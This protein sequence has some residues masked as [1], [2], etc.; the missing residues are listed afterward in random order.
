MKNALKLARRLIL[1]LLCVFA[2]LPILN[3]VVL[4]SVTYGFQSNGRPYSTAE[5]VAAGLTE[6]ADG[7]HLPEE[8]E[9]RLKEEHVWA[10]FR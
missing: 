4:F 2:L 9:N 5:E 1:T 8:I 6:T 7:Y 3:L 10:F